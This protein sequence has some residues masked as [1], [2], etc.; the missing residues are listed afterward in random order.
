MLSLLLLPLHLLLPL[1]LLLHLLIVLIF[2]ILFMPV[3][4]Y[5]ILSCEQH[6]VFLKKKINVVL[7]IVSCL[8]SFPLSVASVVKWLEHR[9]EGI[10]CI[11]AG[12][13]IPTCPS[14]SYFLKVGG[15]QE[16]SQKFVD[17]TRRVFTYTYE[18]FQN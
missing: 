9:I 16:N 13:C 1:L 7:S 6:R 5:N 14:I 2:T 10:T 4:P 15:L 18:P 8:I 3:R 17:I 11:P 12:A